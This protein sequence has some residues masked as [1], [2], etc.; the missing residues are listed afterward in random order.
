MVAGAMELCVRTWILQT[1]RVRIMVNR[2]RIVL[3]YGE[4]TR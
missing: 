3:Y 4:V 1:S 2:Q